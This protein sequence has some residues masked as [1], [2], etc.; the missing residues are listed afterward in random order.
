MLTVLLKTVAVYFIVIF[1]FR[2]MGK[3]QI[4]ELQPSELVLTLLISE[5]AAIPIQDDVPFFTHGVMP[6]FV[7]V[8]LEIFLS[9]IM[10]KSG[11][12]RKFICG[13]PT[14]V[15][16]KGKILQNELKRQRFA[17]EDLF[18]QLRSKDIFSLDE[19]L[20]AIVETD[21]SLSVLRKKEYEPLSSGDIKLAIEENEPELVVI[22]D[23]EICRNSM[24]LCGWDENRLTS[25][26]RKENIRQSEIFLMSAAASGK[27]LI[28]R[29][30]KA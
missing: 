11:R 1:A 26:L 2:L 3:R 8:L 17:I 9:F 29:K 12:I 25:V 6:I 22:S 30:E 28:V 21:G 14:V 27:Y 20:Y 16:S 5:L 10:I 4:K 23:G 15:I 13:S 18:E 19:V 24:K 7:L